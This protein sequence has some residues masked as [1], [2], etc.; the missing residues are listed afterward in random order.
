MA[1]FTTIVALIGQDTGPLVS[2]V[3]TRATNVGAVLLRDFEP[4]EPR[5]R[6]RLAWREAQRRKAIYTLT[7]FD[8]MQPVVDAW[9]QRSTGHEHDLSLEVASTAKMELPEYL[10]VTDD[11]EGEL[12]HWYH[13]LMHGYSSRR[14]VTVERL[15]EAIHSALEHLR[16]DRPFPNADVVA[17]AALDFAPTRLSRSTD[18]GKASIATS[19]VAGPR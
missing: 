2:A 5:N 1:R 8:P 12:V 16:A 19:F 7:D 13:G 11:L 15:P 4:E 18:S 9:A 14:V 10:F 17:R 3:A 6:L